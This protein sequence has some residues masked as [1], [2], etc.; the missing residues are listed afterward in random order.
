MKLNFTISELLDSIVANQAGIKNIPDNKQTLDNMLILI[1]ECLQ[2]LRNF[3]NK[4]MIVTSGYRCPKLNSHPDVKGASNSQHLTG[5][6]CDF[7]V[8]G[9]TPNQVID[10][11]KC[12]GI[13]FDQ[14]INEYNQWVHISYRRGKNRRQFIKV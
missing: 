10:M 2:P 9:L 14:C 13:E 1:T 5:Q 7:V 4:P 6:A 8:N 12:S 3:I 11:V